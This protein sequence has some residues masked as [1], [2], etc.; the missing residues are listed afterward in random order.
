LPLLALVVALA[1]ALTLPGRG[2]SKHALWDFIKLV[3][4]RMELVCRMLNTRD[5]Q[6]LTSPARSS[7][8]RV[9][10]LSEYASLLS[11]G[12]LGSQDSGS[13]KKINNKKHLEY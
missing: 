7:T 4:Q 10:A 6:I 9:T 8:L 13:V 11:N 3:R 5:A 1:H 12:R 2:A